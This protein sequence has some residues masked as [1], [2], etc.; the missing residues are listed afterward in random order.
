M[1][2][3]LAQNEDGAL[4]LSMLLVLVNTLAVLAALG[5]LVYSK[6]IFKRPVITE[7][8]E[9][10]RLEEQKKLGT[11][12]SDNPGYAHFEPLVVNIGSEV[13]DP[14]GNKLHTVTIGI[15]LEIRDISRVGDIDSVRPIIIDDM[16][17]EI[18]KR[19]FEQLITVQGRYVLKTAI[20]ERVNKR[21]K[22]PLVTAVLFTL[23]TAQ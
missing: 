16:L 18:G 23:F 21:L 14:N 8:S 2:R 22:E 6:F 12:F 5:L 7:E 20:E 15:S 19:T 17:Q 3:N 4:N 1:K 10:A 11:M 13:D 9:R